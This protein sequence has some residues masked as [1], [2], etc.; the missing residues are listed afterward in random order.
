M[1]VLFNILFQFVTQAVF[2][3]DRW[4]FSFEI[5]NFFFVT[6]LKVELLVKLAEN[7]DLIDNLFLFLVLGI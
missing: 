4:V 2:Y 6:I 3:V 1:D 7:D 5:S